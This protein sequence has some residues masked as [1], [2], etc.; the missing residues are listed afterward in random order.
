VGGAVI[1]DFRSL[2][3]RRAKPAASRQVLLRQPGP[4][5]QLPKQPP[6]DLSACMEGARLN[7]ARGIGDHLTE[8]RMKSALARMF[9]NTEPAVAKLETLHAR[10]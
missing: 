10:A 8:P 3:D 2:T 1:P 9:A 6:N 5:L 7:A 4:G